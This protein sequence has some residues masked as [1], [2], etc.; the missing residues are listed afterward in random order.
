MDQRLEDRWQLRF[1][2]PEATR[3]KSGRRFLGYSVRKDYMTDALSICWA[4]Y[5]HFQA[6]A[7]QQLLNRNSWGIDEALSELL[8]RIER[9]SLDDLSDWLSELARQRSH[10]LGRPVPVEEGLRAWIKNLA[11]NRSKKYR[12]GATLEEAKAKGIVENP[13]AAIE[14]AEEVEL[15]KQN[16]TE[17]EWRVMWRLASGDTYRNLADELRMGVN[18]LKSFVLRCRRRL[19]LCLENAA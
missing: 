5:A 17:Y 3:Q 8:E 10:R 15:A 18:S 7:N 9:S 14:T 16:S 2:F 12:S 4:E 13:T 19:A 6:F 11:T 1:G